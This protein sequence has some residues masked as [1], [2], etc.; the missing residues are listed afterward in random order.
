MAKKYHP[1]KTQHHS[2][3]VIKEQ[4]DLMFQEVN[5]AYFIL[6]DPKKRQL[7]DAGLDP[8]DP[9]AGKYIYINYML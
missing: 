3:K 8:D 9:N 1:D 4:S 5:H 2:D 7:Y 6:N